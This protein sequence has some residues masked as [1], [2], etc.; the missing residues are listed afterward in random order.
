MYFADKQL[1]GYHTYFSWQMNDDKIEIGAWGIWID[2]GTSVGD[3]WL[4]SE[5]DTAYNDSI[6]GNIEYLNKIIVTNIGS[7]D[8]MVNGENISAIGFK[9]EI[10][11]TNL[12]K[13]DE[14]VKVEVVVNRYISFEKGLIQSKQ[15]RALVN[16]EVAEY[17]YIQNLIRYSIPN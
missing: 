8:F 10:M 4:V 3:S 6:F 5:I 9:Y 14:T 16:G 7:K 12:F 2:F 13:E 17:E 1:F 11:F 15:E